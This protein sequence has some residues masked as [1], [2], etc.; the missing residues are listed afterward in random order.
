MTTVDIFSIIKDIA[1]AG[2]AVT[3]ASV[4]YAGVERWQKELKANASFEVAREVIKATFKLR[5][6][7]SYCRAP[8]K[9][10][11]E[12]PK[13][14]RD[15]P[16]KQTHEEIAD[17]WAHLYTNRWRPV[18]DALAEFEAAALEA[19]VLWGF[20][21]QDKTK[22]LQLCLMNLR[23]YI[24]A[25]IANEYSGQRNFITGPDFGKKV[26]SVIHA[27]SSEENEFT[28]R[29]N[30]AINELENEIRPYLARR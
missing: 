4:A 20:K 29:I 18:G 11:S 17:A 23:A 16:L 30:T 14:Y 1:I 6:E 10:Q 8:F 24:D 15:D 3:T 26:S 22:Q 27:S 12:F 21:I 19:E 28:N 7:V 25:W 13:N 5:D 2:A 9:S